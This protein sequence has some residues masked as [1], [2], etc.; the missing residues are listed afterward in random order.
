MPPFRRILLLVPCLVLAFSSCACEDAPPANECST[1]KDC[2]ASEQCVAGH[3]VAPP[4]ADTIDIPGRDGGETGLPDIN[5]PNNPRKDTDCDGL[6]DAEE[7]AASWGPDAQKTDPGNRDSDGDGLPDGLEAGRTIGVEGTSCASLIFDAD[8]SSRTSPVDPD[9]DADALPDGLEDAD[10]NGRTDPSETNPARPDT[11]ADG[12]LDGT[13]DANH[14]G[15]RGPAETN[16]LVADSDGDGC[17]DGYEDGDRDGTLDPGES[18]PLTAGDCTLGSLDSDGDGLSDVVEVQVTHTDPLKADTD[19]DGL[20]DGE[21]DRNADGV[22]DAGE[23]DPRSADT[24]CDGLYDAEEAGFRTDP[25]RAD[26]DGDGLRDGLEVGRATSPQAGCVFSGDAHPASRTFP[27]KADTDGDGLP[28]GV[29]DENGNGR[30]DPSETSPTNPDSDGDGLADGAEDANGNGVLDPGESD[31]TKADTDGDSI[32]DRIERVVTMTDPTK[33]DTDGDGCL[34]SEE[35]RDWDGTLDPGETDPRLAGD[36]TDT[37]CDGLRD[38]EE[39]VNRNG[40][41]DPGETAFDRADTDGDG[42]SDGLEK[43]VVRSPSPT[44]CPTFHGDLDAASRT[45][46][47]SKD[48]DCDGLSDDEEDRD[49]NGRVDRLETDPARAD[50]DGDGLPDG[51]ERGRCASPDAARCADSFVADR[52]CGASQTDP[53]Q[54]DTDGDGIPDGAEDLNQDGRNDPGELDPTVSDAAGPVTEACAHPRPVQQ[55]DRFAPDLAVAAA[56]E[57]TEVTTLTVGGQA[58]GAMLYDGTSKIAAFAVRVPSLAS[59]TAQEADGRA[60]L[61]GVASLS[62]SITQLF[63]SWDRFDAIAAHYT[64]ANSSS[65]DLK[66]RANAVVDAL[67]PGTAGQLA[68][69]AGVGGTF[70]VQ[71]E[72]LRR[73]GSYA[74]VI[75]AFLPDSLAAQGDHLFRVD[76]L[77]NGT[78]L[79]QFGDVSRPVCERFAAVAIPKVDFVWVVDNSGSMNQWQA[80]VANAADQMAQQLATAP[81]DWRIA[82]LYSDT[83]R[84]QTRVHQPRPFTRSISQFEADAYPGTGGISPERGF[85]PINHMLQAGRWLPASA[86][87]APDKIR[88]GA[89]VVIVWLTD[90]REQSTTWPGVC[91]VCGTPPSACC[92]LSD[93]IN[94]NIALPSGYSTWA[95]YF[96]DL[97]GGLGKAFVAGIVPPVGVMMPGEETM[98][99]E[100]REVITALQG[101]EADMRDR[102]AMAGFIQQIITAAIGNATPT[103]L[104]KPPIS[105]SIKVA[106]SQVAGPGCDKNDMPHSRTHGFDYDG[107]SKS[108]VFY[109]DCR[110]TAN[111]TVAVSYRYWVEQAPACSPPCTA[112]QV[113][114]P[115]T[116]RCVCPNDC[117]GCAAGKVCDPATCTCLC[118]PDCGGTLAPGQTC[119]VATCAPRCEQAVTCALGFKFDETACGCACNATALACGPGFVADPATCSCACQPDCGGCPA[120]QACSR[121]TCSCACDAVSCPEHQS[122]DPATC[123]CGCNPASLAC[124]A[125]HEADAA[126]CSCRCK[127]D[128]GGCARGLRCDAA[129][130]ACICDTDALHCPGT[131]TADPLSCSCMCKPDC[132]GCPAG[133]TCDPSTCSCENGPT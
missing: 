118:P 74:V 71:A 123:T 68:G 30:V 81:I 109:G 70:R 41:V 43:G 3:C 27:D 14:D 24:D 104:S 21:E 58:V 84:D 99:G 18:N 7:F 45:N 17:P 36:C 39:D 37:D 50:S 115:V 130:C 65:Q 4:D 82:T 26:S 59:V 90:A 119:D 55:L 44:L 5:D 122:L 28:D 52:D 66:A 117:G 19:G 73:S 133:T 79:A 20:R 105:A 80:E 129:A 8:P 107:A 96:A 47:L 9:S 86:S 126:T 127:A 98:T 25:R 94:P 48:T 32:P 23:T 101:L 12:L 49:K 87:E 113:C 13:E 103:R 110:P 1:S 128:C 51:L 120:G 16:P 124:D 60:K 33:A 75:M 11:D 116:G 46:A 64:Q 131:Y 106:A 42:L 54:P 2:S 56:P 125:E 77:A 15:V 89:K 83:D 132:G 57:F 76:D 22:L 114:D 112:P 88:Q 108:L 111:Q 29:E 97:P 6:S 67:L 92:L 53:L 31:P 38:D 62:S 35:D 121:S 100:Y 85:A 63:T 61:A 93:L 95:G 69:S 10:H 72:Y 102:A 40:A 78:A 34:D 91:S